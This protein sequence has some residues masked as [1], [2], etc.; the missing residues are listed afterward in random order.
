M[1]KFLAWLSILAVLVFFGLQILKSINS[2]PIPS[3]DVTLV[4]TPTTTFVSGPVILNVIRN[5]ANLETVSMVFAND[6]DITKVWGLEGACRETL[7]YLGY[8]TVTAGVD[9][10]LLAEENVTVK[11]RDDPAQ[12]EITITLPPASILHVELDTKRS[13]VVH[14]ETSIISQ[15]CGTK[16]G[17]MVMEAQA[18]IK[19]IV[20][21]SANQQDILKLAQERASFELQKMLLTMG[22]ARVNVKYD[23]TYMQ[24]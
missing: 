20:E 2:L 18:K 3:V 21:T 6:I 19:N 7:T 8:Y 23:D 11:N 16:L 22:Y 12:T 10:Q 13:R 5:Q 4:T 14:N 1:K 15:I 17:E 9:L 24:Q